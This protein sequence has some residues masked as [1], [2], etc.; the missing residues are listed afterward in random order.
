[1][2]TKADFPFQKQKC[3]ALYRLH[4]RWHRSYETLLRSAGHRFTV[5]GR[6]PIDANPDSPMALNRFVEISKTAEPEMNRDFEE[7]AA[8]KRANER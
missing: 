8:F 3:G 1:M 4:G 5:F 6:T 7:L 2:W